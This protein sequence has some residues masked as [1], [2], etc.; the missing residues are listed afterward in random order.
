M[1]NT[2]NFFKL[3]TENHCENIAW[4]IRV[5][6]KFSF[7]IVSD[8]QHLFNC[9]LLEFISISSCELLVISCYNLPRLFIVLS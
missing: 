1:S 4:N 5:E 3:N 9:N 6:A 8:F 2:T 7:D